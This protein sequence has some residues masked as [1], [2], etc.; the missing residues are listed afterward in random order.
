[1]HLY[2]EGHGVTVYSNNNKKSTC[3]QEHCCFTDSTLEEEM[4]PVTWHGHDYIWTT[5]NRYNTSK[6][7]YRHNYKI[8]KTKQLEKTGQ[9]L[10]A[11]LRQQGLCVTVSIT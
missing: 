6:F 8:T 3:A 1:M 7:T 2:V 9:E 11:F 4:A 5:C 10:E